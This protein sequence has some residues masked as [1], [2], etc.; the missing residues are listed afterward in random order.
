MSAAATVE[1]FRN[2][3]TIYDDNHTWLDKFPATLYSVYNV[4][5]FRCTVCWI[6]RSR[7]KPSQRN[8][9]SK[10]TKKSEYKQYFNKMIYNETSWICVCPLRCALFHGEPLW[11]GKGIKDL[12][13]LK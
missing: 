12:D 7:D 6:H 3:P 1:T 11:S 4:S 8:L 10:R 5:E 13:H 2:W 9:K